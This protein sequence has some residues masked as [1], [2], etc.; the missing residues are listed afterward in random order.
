MDYTAEIDREKN[1]YTI[2]VTGDYER[3]KDAIAL[4]KATN[5]LR[6]KHEINRFLIDY[7][8]ARITGG[9]MDA[10]DSAMAANQTMIPFKFKLAFVYRGDM[11]VPKFMEDVVVNMG[12]QLRVFDDIDL[13]KK[14]LLGK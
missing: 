11:S 8:E 1:L 5:E 12:Y 3:P 7:R 14:W 6:E 13:A 2:C 9:T 10:Y 4:Q